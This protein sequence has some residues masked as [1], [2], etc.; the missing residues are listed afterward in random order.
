MTLPTNLLFP[1]RPEK[2]EAG[3]SD[4]AEYMRDLVKLLTDTYRTAVKNI[5][6]DIQSFTPV[7]S[8]DTTAGLGTYSI[9]TG[10]SLRA[11]LQTHVWF[12]VEWSSHTG[13]GSLYLTLPFK[14]F[15]ISNDPFIGAIG[16]STIAYPV[17]VSYLTL[18]AEPN[19]FKAYLKASGSGVAESY[20]NLPVSGRIKG[21]IFYLGQTN[22]A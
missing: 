10:R 13:T 21:H 16:S 9:Q 7:V 3:G 4:L 20:V 1:F 2:I 12:D 11:G 6:G 17:G 22:E 14:V 8:G 5:D 15:N 19:S 18:N